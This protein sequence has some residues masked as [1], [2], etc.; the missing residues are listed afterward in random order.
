MLSAGGLLSFCR[1]VCETLPP[2]GAAHDLGFLG[3]AD[4]HERAVFMEANAG[5]GTVADAKREDTF[6]DGGVAP[7]VSQGGQRRVV[8]FP[9][10]LPSLGAASFPWPPFSRAAPPPLSG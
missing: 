8:F 6:R 4:I 1:H 9:V 7:M 10:L 3:Q 2:R 5:E